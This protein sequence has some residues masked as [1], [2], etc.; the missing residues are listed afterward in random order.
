MKIIVIGSKGMLG[1]YL[2]SV[3][4]QLDKYTVF[5]L[6]KTELDIVNKE[7][8]LQTLRE[9]KPELVVNAV[10]YNDV[11]KC[12]D[13]AG[14]TIALAINRDGVK[15]LSD[16]CKS[17]DAIFVQYSTDY[18]FNG[19][20]MDGY[21]EEDSPAPINKYGQSKLAGENVLWT[22][23]PS[24]YYLIRT[25]RL[26]GTRGKSLEAKTSFVDLMLTLATKT[27]T[28]STVRN[29]EISS[30][31]YAKDLAWATREIVEAKSPYGIYHITNNG[32]CDWYG[33]AKEIFKTK[34]IN[35]NLIP[36]TRSVFKGL[37]KRPAFSL[38]I[39][40][41]LPQLRSWQEALREYLSEN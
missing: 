30:P 35:I 29:E 37:A 33:F 6:D 3:F 40:T 20:S 19:D 21:T 14:Y 24:K 26:F 12:E 10:A 38:L 32:S 9:I 34:N 4:N 7:D 13:G 27:S 15:N 28:I 11:E 39:N 18:V 36:V 41:K 5:A 8:V 22:S 1:Q 31:T 25:S 23:K 16:A 17:I 2:V